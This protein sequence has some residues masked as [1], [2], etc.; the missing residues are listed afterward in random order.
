MDW[1]QE[2]NGW[3]DSCGY[4]VNIMHVMGENDQFNAMTPWNKPIAIGM[5]SLETA[6]QWIDYYKKKN[7]DGFGVGGVVGRKPIQ[8]YHEHQG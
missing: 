7:F 4:H 5:P 2:R 8:E 6:K 1:D 3:Y